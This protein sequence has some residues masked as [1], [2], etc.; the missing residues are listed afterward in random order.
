MI[1]SV[2]YVL[3]RTCVLSPA[4]EK[5]LYHLVGVVL[6]WSLWHA[7]PV[8]NFFRGT[9][10]DSIAYGRGTRPPHLEDIPDQDLN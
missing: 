10:Y 6:A 7:G 2:N 9:L 8:G 1:N 4:H 5:D 3:V